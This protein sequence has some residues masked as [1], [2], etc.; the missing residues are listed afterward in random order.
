M[1]WKNKKTEECIVN[2]NIRHL[3]KILATQ[4]ACKDVRI[5]YIILWFNVI[6]VTGGVT[7]VALISYHSRILFVGN[8]SNKFKEN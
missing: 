2:E 6:I 8:G 1:I 7:K 3:F 4:E 5:T